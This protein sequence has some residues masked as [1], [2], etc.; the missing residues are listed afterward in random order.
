M[1]LALEE[2]FHPVHMENCESDDACMVLSQGIGT[3][4]VLEMED[5]TKVTSDY[6]NVIKGKYSMSQTTDEEKRASYGMRA[7]NDLNE[8]NFACFDKLLGFLCCVF[9]LRL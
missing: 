5:P 2:I 3:C 7:N 8:Q 6:L 4:I 1:K 9:G